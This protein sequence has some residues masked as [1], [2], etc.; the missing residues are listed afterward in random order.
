[1]N[2]GRIIL[3]AITTL[4]ASFSNQTSHVEGVVGQPQ[5]LHPL[6]IQKNTFDRDL[7]TLVFSGLTKIAPDGTVNPDL[8]HTWE[9]S[10]DEK[11]YTFYLDPERKWHDGKPVT[12]DDVIFTVE[13]H[14]TFRELEVE[15]IDNRTVKFKLEEPF[16]PFLHLL[17][18]G[19]APK[20]IDYE[21][22]GYKFI[23]S[24]PY[25]IINVK[26]GI[27]KI[28]ELKL[29]KFNASSKG[30]AKIIFRFYET[31]DE[32]LEAAK[33]GELDGFAH[34]QI[35]CKTYHSVETPLLGRYFAL[36]FNL[37]DKDLLKEKETRRILAEATPK[38]TIIDKLEQV[39]EIKQGS[40][41]LPEEIELPQTSSTET[42]LTGNISLTYPKKEKYEQIVELLK[43]SWEELGIEVTLE[44]KDASILKETVVPERDFDV[45]LMG[46]EVSKDPDRYTLW[47]STQASYPGLNLTGLE[48]VRADRALEEA[49]RTSDGEER[50]EH[51]QNLKNVTEEEIPAIF[52]YR[53][54]YIYHIRKRLGK[55]DLEGIYTPED[56]WER[57]FELY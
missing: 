36:F 11:E 34:G 24:G 4:L 17:N 47:H 6:T 35:D 10:E 28:D 20:H 13:N 19:V 38:E 1:M 3:T 49:R 40:Y 2:I 54:T 39:A 57:I 21:Q 31:K 45:L 43:R 42:T 51:Y 55:P 5:N 48:N 50:K 14:T 37:R 56:R 32:L 33:L 22:E 44:A 52:L 16:S 26:K 29:K 9:I 8:A 30:P 18:I 7:G 25:K 46:Q 15:K 41:P 27:R 23:G 53:P 12:A